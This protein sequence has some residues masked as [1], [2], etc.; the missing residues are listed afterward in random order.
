MR[1]SNLLPNEDETLDSFFHGRVRVLQKKRGYRFSVDAPLLA[2]FVRTEGTDELLEI[3]TGVG[4]ISLLLC[5][6]PLRRITAVEVQPSLA[7]LARRNVVLNALEKKITVVEAD[8]R[9]YEPRQKFDVVLSNPP[10][11]KKRGG[12]VSLSEEKSIA[13]HELKGDIFDIMRKTREFLKEEGRA[14]F[15]YPEKRREDFFEAVE[16]SG[17]IFKAVR[18]I[19]PRA[20]ESANL[21]LSECVLTSVTTELL[22]PLVLYEADGR[23]G[24]EARAIFAGRGVS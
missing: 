21:F 12:Q 20:A 16:A 15:I 1:Q 13:K 23:Y 11:I 2:D 24:A 3:G 6:K 9:T 18:P 5:A 8:Y 10:Y 14:Y 22:P 17:L 7:E 19:R 4:I